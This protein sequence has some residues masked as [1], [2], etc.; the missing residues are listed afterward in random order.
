[1]LINLYIHRFLDC[2][3]FP[4]GVNAKVKEKMSTTKVGKV[5]CSI[6]K[7]KIVSEA[8][9]HLGDVEWVSLNDHEESVLSLA[10]SRLE[11]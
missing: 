2:S 8:S 7:H 5:T 3:N 6:C 10:A 9:R 1:M 11:Q 4:E